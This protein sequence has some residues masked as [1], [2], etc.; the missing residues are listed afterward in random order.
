MNISGASMESVLANMA[1]SNAH[2]QVQN[3]VAVLILKQ[4]MQQ[5]EIEGAALVKMINESSLDGTGQ[6]VNRTA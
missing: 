4:Q 5:N 6:L 1:T 2:Q 3:E